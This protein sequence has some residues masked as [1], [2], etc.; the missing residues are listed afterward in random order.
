MRQSLQLRETFDTDGL[1]LISDFVEAGDRVLV[2]QL[3][4]T[5]GRGPEANIESTAVFSLRDGK[6]VEQT[7]FWDHGEAL[8]AASVSG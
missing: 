2:R 4:R 3:W 5:A 7:L 8:K 6:V 1:E